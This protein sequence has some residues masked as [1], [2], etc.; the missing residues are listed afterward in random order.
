MVHVSFITLGCPKNEADTQAM[1][2]RIDA[3]NYRLVDD[4]EQADVVIVNTCSFIQSATEESL[5]VILDVARTW[6]N[7][8]KDRHLLVAGCMPSRYGEELDA[9]LPEVSAFLSVVNEHNICTTIERLTGV[10][11][12]ERA[13]SPSALANAPYAYI[14]I[15]DGCDKDCAYCTIPHIRGPYISRPLEDIKRE[16]TQLVDQGVSEFILI[17]QDS[18]R[19]GFDLE[20]ELRLDQLIDEVADMDGVKRVRIMYLQP[21]GVTDK[22]I[23]AIRRNRNVCRYIE[24]PLQHSSRSVLRSMGRAGDGAQYK[25]LVA[26]IRRALPDVVIRTTTIVGYPGETEEDFT[27]LI[28]FISDIE[29][30]YVGIFPF[31]PEEG[32]RAATLDG[33][34]PDDIKMQRYQELRDLADG[35]GWAKASLKVGQER[36]VLV[37]GTDGDGLYG[38]TCGQ[39]PDIDGVVHLSA[40]DETLD[41]TIGSYVNAHITDSI[42]YDLDG[43]IS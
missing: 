29:F 8:R 28:E 18:T 24:M 25:D 13:D 12:G 21:E 19:W 35:I 5:E 32:T 7:L 22:I 42:L 23:D 34:I 16:I 6:L 33:Q 37:E 43:M 39:A 41:V 36:E 2:A 11:S 26:R 30:D 10:P 27:D 4:I 17:A 40:R 1:K 3:S 9:E 38:R 14:K 31:S 15:A 20:G